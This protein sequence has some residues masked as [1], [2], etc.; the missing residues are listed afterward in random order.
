MSAREPAQAQAG[1]VLPASDGR[2]RRAKRR[3]TC[4]FTIW[5]DREELETIRAFA[6]ARSMTL[7]RFFLNLALRYIASQTKG[8]R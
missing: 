2:Y 5:C 6:H 7:S 3:E 4:K 8:G 1:A